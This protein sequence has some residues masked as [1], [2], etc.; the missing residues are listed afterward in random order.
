MKITE[1]HENFLADSGVDRSDG[2]HVSE[3]INDL[4]ETLEKTHRDDPPPNQLQGQ[5][6]KGFIWERVL[7]RGF[8][9]RA[10]I[11]PGEIH[12]D[13]L[14]GSPDGINFVTL[15][16]NGIEYGGPT[17]VLEEYKCTTYSSR[18]SP[19]ENLRWMMQVKAYC[20]MWTASSG[21][22]LNHCIFRVLHLMGDYKNRN[23]MPKTWLLTFGRLELEENWRVIINHAKERGI[24]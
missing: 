3:V 11:R 7:S 12:C 16:N 17:M 6:E 22:L 4:V 23:P 13:G 21:E 14:A 15:T 18:R 24:L 5:F 2:A 1:L 8:G 9:E 20:Y 19:D 10:A